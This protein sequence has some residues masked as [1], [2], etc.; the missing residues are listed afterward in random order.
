MKSVDVIYVY[1][2]SMIY[3]HV[4]H[5]HIT[6]TFSSSNHAKS[7]N[8][9]PL[10][11]FSLFLSFWMLSGL[12][13]KTAQIYVQEEMQKWSDIGVEGHFAGRRPWARIDESVTDLSRE[14]VGAR[15]GEEVAI[16][17]SL[18]VNLHLLLISFY[19]P[20]ASRYKI[21]MEEQAFCSDHHVIHSQ[22]QLH[23]R[24]V[25]DAVVY[26]KPREGESWMRTEDIVQVIEKEGDSIAVILLP[27]RYH[28]TTT[29]PHPPLHT[30]PSQI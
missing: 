25:E 11:S 2:C 1:M 4:H 3:M 26:V 10:T 7:L 15:S 21:L 9:Y 5:M 30:S 12:Q 29:Y 14:I 23:N 19:R 28:I 22:V 20:T 13:P 16:M 17:N 6:F 27:V 24:S 8:V 18:S